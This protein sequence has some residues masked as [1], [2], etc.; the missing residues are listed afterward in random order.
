MS[1]NKNLE[2]YLTT[3]RFKNFTE[4]LEVSEIE[5][6]SIGIADITEEVGETIDAMIQFWNRVDG[7]TPIS[8]RT[9][10][11]IY[12]NSNGGDLNATLQM[13]NSIEL[14]E[15]P[16]YT[17]VTGTAYSGGFFTSIAGHKRFCY[18]NA[19]FLYH[20]G[21]CFMGGDASKF[22]NQ[23]DFYNKQMDAIKEITLKYTKISEELYKQKIKDD[24]WFTAEE[25][26]ELGIVDE[27]LTKLI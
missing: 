9:P 7:L 24:W 26:L 25:A 1:I 17:I 21:S 14:S 16:V 27:I 8:S 15:T 20:E 12:I 22:R 5:H 23:A 19:S 2:R 13:I 3:T 10:I 18:R 4:L 11:K 6:R